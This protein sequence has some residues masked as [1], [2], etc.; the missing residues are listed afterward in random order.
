MGRQQPQRTLLLTNSKGKS[1]LEEIASL[2]KSSG[3][4][5]H[6]DV[7]PFDKEGVEDAFRQLKERRTKGK[8]VF[9]IE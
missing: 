3:A 4:K 7:K 6:L 9:N 1:D 5:P 2:L 8:I